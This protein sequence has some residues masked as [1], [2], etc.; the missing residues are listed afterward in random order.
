MIT[1]RNS[2]PMPRRW[3]VNGRFLGRNM[4]GVDRYALEILAHMDA[5][6]GAQH[7]LTLGLALEILCPAVAMKTSPFANIPLRRLPNAPG[8]LWEQCILPRYLRGGGLLNLCNTGPVTLKKQIVCIHD[9]NS[10]L[11]PE[12]Y[13]LMFRMVYRVLIPALGRRAAR[14]VTVSRFSQQAIA[15]LGIRAAD[16]IVVIHDGYEH[17]LEWKADR[18]TLD[19]MDL[20]RPFVLLVG[21]KS[22]HKNVAV[23]Y[24][25]AADLAAKGIH[26]LV[27]GGEDA[28][29]YAR[30]HGGQLPPNVKHLGRVDDNDL[31]FLYQN[32]LCL[33]FPSRTEGFGLPALEAM[34]L[35]CPV[36]SSD[37]ASLPEVCGEAALYAPPNNGLAWL[38]AIERI[39]AEPTLRQRLASAGRKRAKAFSWQQGAEKYLALMLAI[40]QGGREKR[41]T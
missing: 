9:V 21:S 28:N 7:P 15:R 6:I 2:T 32:A 10:R 24:S 23:I 18:S 4:T 20:P 25:I 39:A 35:G 36:V 33:G 1:V 38:A 8:H 11:V 13:G 16:E 40:E 22:P 26:V 29:V 17:V 30:D 41:P 12:S 5:L 14:I 37:A 31:A 34:A 19:G 3:S 27:A